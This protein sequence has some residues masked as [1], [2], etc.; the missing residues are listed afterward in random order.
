M[1]QTEEQLL[2]GRRLTMRSWTLALIL[3]VASLGLL[4]ATASPA[5][6]QWLPWRRPYVAAYYG[7][8]AY[9]YGYYP[10]AS[11]YTYPSY[12]YSYAAPAYSYYAAPTGY[13]SYY[14][15]GYYGYSYYPGYRAYYPRYGYWRY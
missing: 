4:G 3:G 5:H 9:N 2:L 7:Y 6:A 8:P 10:Y 11:Y 1:A 12:Y 15:P 14:T 13:Y